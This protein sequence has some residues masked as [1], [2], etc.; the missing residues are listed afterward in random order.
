ML[1]REALNSRVSLHVNVVTHPLQRLVRLLRQ[2]RH[3]KRVERAV[4]HEHRRVLVHVGGQVLELLAQ[5]QPRREAHDAS[6]LDGGGE[7]R[8]DRHGAT[9]GEAAEDDAVGGDAG[10]DLLLDQLV[11]I[12]AALEDAALV[13]AALERLDRAVELYLSWGVRIRQ[14]GGE[15]IAG[16]YNVEPRRRGHAHVLAR[17]LVFLAW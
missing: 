2:L 6:D 11:E 8:E 5:E 14:P 1:T 12:D 9:L 3:N 4:A 15:W 13:L 7:A 17:E 10:V 16:S